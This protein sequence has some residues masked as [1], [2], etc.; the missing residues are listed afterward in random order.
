M[1]KHKKINEKKLKEAGTILGITA[2]IIGLGILVVATG[3]FALGVAGGLADAGVAG[4]L[5]GGL[6]G[7]GAVTGSTLAGVAGGVATAADLASTSIQLAETPKGNKG[8]K[9]LLG[10]TI[11]GDALSLGTMGATAS[12]G[13]L[14]TST[15]AITGLAK[16]ATVAS[17]L[18]TGAYLGVSGTEIGIGIKDHNKQSIIAGSIGLGVMG[19]GITTSSVHSSLDQK[20]LLEPGTVSPTTYTM[21]TSI[22]NRPK[23]MENDIDI[24]DDGTHSVGSNVTYSEY[25]YNDKNTGFIKR[26]KNTGRAYANI[27]EDYPLSNKFTRFFKSSYDNEI[28]NKIIDLRDTESTIN[29]N[30]QQEISRLNSAIR[31]SIARYS[32]YHLSAPLIGIFNKI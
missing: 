30:N 29:P 16:G 26:A 23:I 27:Y 22:E 9:A 19:M 17:T 11:A 7:A 20:S 15:K 5:A 14:A 1:K 10:L 2:G 8:Q 18:S 12:I 13:R 28:S 21:R 3:G 24:A 25:N 4:G 6:A 31:E 32:N